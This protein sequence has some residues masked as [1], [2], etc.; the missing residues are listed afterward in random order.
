MGRVNIITP[1]EGRGALQVFAL[2]FHK[3]L[4]TLCSG[5]EAVWR[6]PP[7]RLKMSSIR[8]LGKGEPVGAAG[9]AGPY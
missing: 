5:Q 8:R 7:L 6:L 2:V 1:S 4:C 9:Q 3:V